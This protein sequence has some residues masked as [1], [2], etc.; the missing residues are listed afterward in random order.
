MDPRAASLALASGLVR[1]CGREE[2]RGDEAGCAGS[3]AGS[4]VMLVEE[5]RIDVLLSFSVSAG[6]ALLV[7]VCVDAFL[8]GHGVAWQGIL[9]YRC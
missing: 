7:C 5:W 9:I 6:F 4:S 3:A 8:R 1:W 2:G